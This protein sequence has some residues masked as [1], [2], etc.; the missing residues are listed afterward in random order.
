MYVCVYGV[1]MYV[2]G[3]TI[4]TIEQHGFYQSSLS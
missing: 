4:L 3:E 2:I 1:H